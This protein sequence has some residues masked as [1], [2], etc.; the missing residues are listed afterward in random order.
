MPTPQAMRLYEEVD[1]IFAGIHQL[2]RAV[3]VVKREEHAQLIVG[4]LPALA[5][6]FIQQAT[7]LFL[8]QH[9]TVFVSVKVRASMV[10]ADW[11]ATR[12]IDVGVLNARVDHPDLALEP[13][14][15]HP[16]VCILPTSHRLAQKRSLTLDDLG[17]EPFVA[18]DNSVE[19]R[20][21]VDQLFEQSG[22]TPRY[23]LE[24]TSAP[25]LCEF[26]AAGLGLSLVHP[27][28]A[29]TVTGR[30]A[31]RPFVP[32]VNNHFLLGRSH[33]SRNTRYVDDF[34]QAA[35]TVA[36]LKSV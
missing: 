10:L 11:L 23:V 29:G 21:T 20:R 32:T 6:P 14:L 36:Q 18:F 33:G 19:I 26:V 15:C 30:I 24:A 8:R 25:T 9:P 2:S 5:G 1:R 31:T 3:D 17:G 27:H 4:V 13:L 34:I 22:V 7:M 12:Q 28:M 16:L 35:H